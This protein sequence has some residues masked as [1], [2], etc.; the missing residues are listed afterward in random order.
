MLGIW[1]GSAQEEW[2]RKEMG[3]TLPQI[4]CHLIK[5][6]PCCHMVLVSNA[7]F[8]QLSCS[9][10]WEVGP[11][12]Q[13]S[14]SSSA[15]RGRGCGVGR[16]TGTGSS[17]WLASWRGPGGAGRDSGKGT[18]WGTRNPGEQ[19]QRSASIP[20]GVCAAFCT[21]VAGVMP[22]RS[23]NVPGSYSHQP[24]PSP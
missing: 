22:L 19:G 11:V 20:L 9:R 24:F 1:V 13:A 2:K 4:S 7:G 16:A 12:L 18:S 15:Q 8:L 17:R 5:R 14:A 10:L 3:E 23:K 21:C 6:W